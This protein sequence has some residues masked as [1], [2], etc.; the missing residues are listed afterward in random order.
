MY[1][2]FSVKRRG[3]RGKKVCPS[4][5]VHEEVLKDASKCGG[6]M[7]GLGR[8]GKGWENSGPLFTSSYFCFMKQGKVFSAQKN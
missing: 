2:I 1:A 7:S 8:R 6:E 5:C 3:W 4:L